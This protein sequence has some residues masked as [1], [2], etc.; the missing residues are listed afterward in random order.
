M[1]Q[2]CAR[3][4]RTIEMPGGAVA[5]C[6]Y[7]GHG[8]DAT[9][10]DHP[11]TTRDAVSGRA[12]PAVREHIGEY[13]L[14]RRLGQ[15]GMG[16]VYEGQHESTGRRVA[17][18]LVDVEASPEALERFRQEGRL[19]SA[20]SHPRCVFVLAADEDAGQPYLVLELMPGRTLDDL[21]RE[22]GPLPLAEALG[23]ALDLIEGLEQV[24]ALG[25]IHR[26]VKPSNC[27][28][29]EQGR[30]KVGDFGLA[31]SLV[32]EARLT[33]TGTFIGTP[34]FAAPEQ[35]KSQPLDARADVY[36]VCATLYFLL[37][38]RAPH[39]SGDGDALGVMARAVSDEPP[40]LRSR[41]PDLPVGLERVLARGLA[42]ERERRWP[43][44]ASLREALTSFQVAGV[45]PLFLARRLFAYLGD[46]Y[47]LGLVV[48][49]VWWPIFGVPMDRV[50]PGLMAAGYTLA[51]V[52]FGLCEGVWGVTAGK[53]LLGLRVARAGDVAPPG[54]RR[55]LWRAGIWQ[56]LMVVIGLPSL[57]FQP[58]QHAGDIV[59]AGLISL[60]QVVL[61]LLTVAAVLSTARRRNGYRCLHDV[62]S[63]TRVVP[64]P[65]RRVALRLGGPPATGTHPADLP[66]QLGPY[67][68]RD[69]RWR[70]G[71]DRVLGSIDS[72]LG[73]GVW[74]WQRPAGRPALTQARRDLVRVSRL[75][76]LGQGEQDGTRWDAFLAP[77]TV[78]LAQAVRS[79]GPLEWEQARGVLE[80]LTDEL[81]RARQEDTFPEV[82]SLS[83]VWVLPGGGVVLLDPPGP[84]AR[85]TDPLDLLAEVA[86][87][88]LGADPFSPHLPRRPLPLHVRELLAGLPRFGGTLSDVRTFQARLV[89]SQERPAR[90]SGLTRLLHLAVL[91]GV[92]L[93]CCGCL[94]WLPLLLWGAVPALGNFTLYQEA[95]R[96]LGELDR[97]RAAD[98][99]LLVAPTLHPA[100]RWAALAVLRRHDRARKNLLAARKR[101]EQYAEARREKLLIPWVRLN[102]P[103]TPQ[104]GMPTWSFLPRLS[105]EDRVELLTFQLRSRGEP[106]QEVF[107]LAFVLLGLSL[108]LC[109]GSALVFRGGLRYLLFGVRLVRGDGELAGRFRCAWRAL[110][111]W[112]VCVGPLAVARVLEESAWLEWKPGGGPGR[113]LVAANACW[114][115]AVLVL[116]AWL[117]VLVRT[118][119]RSL[120]DRLA[121]TTLVPR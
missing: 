77:A 107:A 85:P 33:R 25:V 38:G 16:V 109:V 50:S 37:A 40:P 76:W 90:V 27:F 18:K 54:W 92:Q 47:L 30:V 22:R 94:G 49:V 15:G 65:P 6:P 87:V 108:G 74:V 105:L 59:A 34:L 5:F 97:A 8:L 93:M 41:R 24:H 55:G 43:D 91:L 89:A 10:A 110:A 26:D 29:D 104:G 7:C 11:S 84:G 64:A 44:L 51:L 106:N 61:L 81:I 32:P 101:A 75:R 82:L 112:I 63:G 72:G 119:T 56:T 31:R 20:V 73:R 116:I 80:A 2:H 48:L 57:W 79:S 52:Y 39:D 45:G 95:D 1:S 60:I 58:A 66:G 36:S 100:N 88:L 17:V 9:T 42:R 83:Q 113:L 28:L 111:A 35:I 14:L 114:A 4:Q 67:A 118:P 115:V 98:T 120:H 3:C 102:L 86:L 103:Q 121:G 71:E 13:R 68:I 117:V 19:A 53:W 23:H 96:L 70:E 21:V 99:A 69:E 62:L 46:H 12:T 78:P